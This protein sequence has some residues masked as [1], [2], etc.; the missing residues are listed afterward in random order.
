MQLGV[1]EG[2]AGMFRGRTGSRAQQGQS[3]SHTKKIERNFYELIPNLQL[4]TWTV[5][6]LYC[7]MQLTV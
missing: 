4:K 2:A 7:I 1:Q 5:V 6:Q 3:T